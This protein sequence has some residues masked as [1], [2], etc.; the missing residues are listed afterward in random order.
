MC[1]NPRTRVGCDDMSG[2]QA[3][4]T[5]QFQSTHPRGVRL[6]HSP[7]FSRYAMFQSTHPRG[8]RPESTLR[9]RPTSVRFQST[10][11][12]GVRLIFFGFHGFYSFVSIHAPAW[13]ATSNSAKIMGW[14]TGFNPRTRVG[15][16]RPKRQGS[17]SGFPFQS[18]HPRGVRPVTGGMAAISANKFQSTHPRGVRPASPSRPPL[19]QQVSIHAPAWGATA[20]RP[21][22]KAG[23]PGFNPR[24][25]VGCDVDAQLNAGP[26]GT[27][28]STHPRGVRRTTRKKVSSSSSFQSTHPRGVRPA[29]ACAVCPRGAVSIHAPAWGATKSRLAMT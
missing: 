1:F 11:P 14:R 28:Q 29:R 9:K 3:L 20:A 24:T 22:C 8:V 18:T 15:C 12:R 19:C 23:L 4:T 2:R 10:H 26:E 7:P 25:R 5:Y 21:G 16:D 17:T 27:F 13:G 6:V